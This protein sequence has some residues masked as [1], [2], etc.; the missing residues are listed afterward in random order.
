MQTAHFVH[1]VSCDLVRERT[2][3]PQ[4][5][6]LHRT[7]VATA[8]DSAGALGEHCAQELA[9]QQT[10]AALSHV[11]HSAGTPPFQ[12]REFYLEQIDMADG[13]SDSS[14][15]TRLLAAVAA[16]ALCDGAC[17]AACAVKTSAAALHTVAS[18]CLED[19][20][21]LGVGQ[22][23]LQAALVQLGVR[24]CSQGAPAPE[25]AANALGCRCRAQL[26]KSLLP[27]TPLHTELLKPLHKRMK[28]AFGDLL[29]EQQQRSSP[30]VRM[31]AARMPA[32][33]ARGGAR[34]AQTGLCVCSDASG[35]QGLQLT[36][37]CDR[38]KLQTCC[39]W[40]QVGLT[41]RCDAAALAQ[42]T[43]AA[44]LMLD[45][46]SGTDLQR[47]PHGRSLHGANAAAAA[48]RCA[49]LIG[50]DSAWCSEAFHVD[51]IATHER[52][53]LVMHVAQEDV[54]RLALQDAG[55]VLCFVI[56]SEVR[57]I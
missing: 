30:G 49:A 24:V 42:L 20:G 9:A 52:K 40:L 8:A 27:Q 11:L 48:S 26:A 13:G 1:E 12:L 54:K 15:A 17:T 51:S 47:Q 5:K 14:S 32:K 41:S 22:R 53:K 44:Q 25:L 16:V 50:R 35:L 43:A 10:A 38:A 39:I 2:F 37:H 28:P 45:A 19:A 55:E 21:E 23:I 57:V 7:L 4:L 34:H 31:L 29:P 56:L 46:I 18:S 3:W 36:V 33:R 6:L